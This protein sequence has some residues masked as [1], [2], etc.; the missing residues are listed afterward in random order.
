MGDLHLVLP[1]LNLSTLEA[2][3]WIMVQ[4]VTLM[5]F[6]LNMM[7]Y[8]MSF[9]SHL[10]LVSPHSFVLIGSLNWVGLCW[11][12]AEEVRGLG[13]WDQG[14]TILILDRIKFYPEFAL[15]EIYI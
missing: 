6:S 2:D 12:L 9:H 1:A 8:S 11:G 13:V 10:I 15:C 14:S 3:I 4:Q 7:D 5:I